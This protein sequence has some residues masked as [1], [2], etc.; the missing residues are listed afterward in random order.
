MGHHQ[1]SG[2]V[3]QPPAQVNLD[4]CQDVLV[5]AAVHQ[6]GYLSVLV[7]AHTKDSCVSGHGSDLKCET[8]PPDFAHH[9]SHAFMSASRSFIS[10]SSLSCH[11]LICM[12]CHLCCSLPGCCC[13]MMTR[14]RRAP[15]RRAAWWWCPGGRVRTRGAG[16]WRS[17]LLLWSRWGCVLCVLHAVFVL[18]SCPL[19]SSSAG[20]C[21]LTEH[22]T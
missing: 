16:W 21:N 2:Q 6:Q 9:S 4:D 10:L 14:T 7:Q 15:V 20:P 8:R 13:L 18:V 5:C 22:S 11:A 1:A 19:C 17:W 3:V 12:G